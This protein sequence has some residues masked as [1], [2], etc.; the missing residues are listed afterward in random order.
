[1]RFFKK[2]FFRIV[3]LFPGLFGVMML[4]SCEKYKD[5]PGETDPRLSRHYC[6]DPDAVNFNR[7]F[8]GIA[9]NSVCT[10]PAD[11]FAGNYSFVDS[12]YDGGQKLLKETPLVLSFTAIDHTKFYLTGF[13]A[14]GSQQYFTTNRSLLASADTTVGSGQLLCRQT[15]TLSGNIFQALGDST[16]VRFSLVVVSDTAVTYHQG[17]A[18]RQ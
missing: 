14:A 9:D 3:V 13:C 12:I 10:Y 16:K 8:P 18:Y 11:V 7:D 1:M 17:T 6:N 15:D 4:S 5:T 2:S